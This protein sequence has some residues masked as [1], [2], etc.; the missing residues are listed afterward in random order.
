MASAIGHKTPHFP[1]L[2]NLTTTESAQRHVPVH[3]QSVPALVSLDQHPNDLCQIPFLLQGRDEPSL[4]HCLFLSDPKIKNIQIHIFK[5]YNKSKEKEYI[6]VCEN[7]IK[8]KI[9]GP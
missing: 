8:L 1:P 3:D 9:Q 4:P 5:M 2:E 6:M 7:N